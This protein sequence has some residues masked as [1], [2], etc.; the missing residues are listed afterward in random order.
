LKLQ[1]RPTIEDVEKVVIS[2]CAKFKELVEEKGLWRSLYNR[3]TGEPLHESAA[4]LMFYGI[5]DSYCSANNIGITP[6]ANAGRGPVDFKFNIGYDVS[7]LVEVKLSTNKQLLH[8]FE[9]QLPEYQKAEKTK[10]GKFLVID[11]GNEK[12]IKRLFRLRNE[13][14]EKSVNVAE[15][16]VVDASRRKSASKV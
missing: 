11:L 15:I 12:P 16:L 4:Q 8:G 5:A 9:K 3:K 2:I 10:K 14:A 13:L 7:I 1:H 6:E